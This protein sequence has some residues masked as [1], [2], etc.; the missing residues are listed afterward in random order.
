MAIERLVPDFVSA[1]LRRRYTT[2]VLN[3]LSDRALADLVLERH[4]IKGVA[5]VAARP[6][7]A[8]LTMAQLVQLARDEDFARTAPARPA[9]LPAGLDEARLASH[10]ARADAIADSVIGASR[11]FAAVL[12]WV[13]APFGAATAGKAATLRR[14]HR[15]AYERVVAELGAYSDRELNADLRIG[16]SQ[17]PELAEAEAARRVA[18]FVRR[19]PDYREALQGFGG[20]F[21]DGLA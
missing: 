13:A 11:G 16:R 2:K 19:N 3:R 1:A 15:E 5:R 17:V 14:V 7:S 20:R 21:A 10:Q 6:E 18:Q 4:D 8:A 12:R 9:L